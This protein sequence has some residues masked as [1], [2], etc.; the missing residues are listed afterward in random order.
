MTV[1]IISH[2]SLH[3]LDN[4]KPILTSSSDEIQLKYNNL[5][6]EY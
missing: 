2:Y 3:H 6:A 5:I 4:Y 1:S